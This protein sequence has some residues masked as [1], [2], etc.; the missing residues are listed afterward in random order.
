MNQCFNKWNRLGKNTSQV[1]KTG[2]RFLEDNIV[3]YCIYGKAPAIAIIVGKKVA[4]KSVVRNK[5]KRWTREVFRIQKNTLLNFQMAV[6]YKPG[7]DKYDYKDVSN[8]L[9]LLW[10]KAGIKK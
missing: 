9:N 8:K 5:L 2:K 1:I 6:I 7:A 3:F 10:I 4:K